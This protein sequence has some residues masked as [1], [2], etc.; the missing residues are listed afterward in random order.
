MWFVR[1]VD[2]YILYKP[3][4]KDEGEVAEEADM[5]VVKDGLREQGREL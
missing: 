4:E 1:D 5:Q 3:V 2:A